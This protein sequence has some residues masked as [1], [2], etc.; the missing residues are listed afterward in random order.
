VSFAP[1]CARLATA[2]VSSDNDAKVTIWNSDKGTQLQTLPPGKTTHGITAVKCLAI[3]PDGR[4]LA[5]G[6]ASGMLRL[7]AVDPTV[8]KDD[9]GA[10][11]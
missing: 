5:A 3:S 10:T 4:T 7:W 1:T 2:S 9:S 11:R 8:G 6:G